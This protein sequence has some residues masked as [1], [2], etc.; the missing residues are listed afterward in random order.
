M[1]TEQKLT[2][3]LTEF[4]KTTAIFLPDDIKQALEKM[5]FK[6]DGERAKAMYGCIEENIKRAAFTRRP[7]CQDTGVPQFFIRIGTQC[8][9][10]DIIEKSIISAVKSATVSVPLR[11]NAIEYFS[12]K[13]TGNN[14]GSNT[15]YISY[16]LIPYSDELE[17]EFY[18]SGGGSSLPG[19]A[20]VLM[21]LEGYK[22]IAD[23]VLDTIVDYGINAC[24]PLIV[25]VGLSCC[26][27]TAA[28]LSKK[29]LL[30]D[31]GR[32]NENQKAAEME[33]N[34]KTALNNI[35]IGPMG[36]KGKESVLSVNIE[37]A[38]H[39]PATLAV[40]VSVGCWATRKGRI[41]IKDDLSY[42]ITSHKG[43]I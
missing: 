11:P 33:E 40:G 30:R 12:D 25:G 38:T 39:H 16:E 19:R 1:D 17:I 26:A 36:L 22:G 6:E 8:K 14:C 15:P 20:K 23:F 37:Y 18:M 4:I 13:N 28:L 35:G 2:I 9:F 31:I 24:P 7:I 43:A 21:P 41:V 3:I 5:S 32:P 42:K 10:K 34:L 29:A 27:P